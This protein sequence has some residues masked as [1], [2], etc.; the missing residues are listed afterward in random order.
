[1]VQATVPQ[2]DCQAGDKSPPPGVLLRVDVEFADQDEVGAAAR[3]AKDPN[4]ITCDCR[5]PPR[6]RSMVP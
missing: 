4:R 2:N 5:E 1:M 3:I 6:V